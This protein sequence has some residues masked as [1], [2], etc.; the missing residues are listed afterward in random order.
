[1]QPFRS[2][3]LAFTAVT[4]TSL[5]QG[6][7]TFC[8]AGT[9]SHRCTPSIAANVQ[10]NTANHAGCVITT[11]GVEGQ[12][13]G[14][15]FY[16]VDNS[17]F[18]PLVWGVG[19]SSWLC[20]KAPTAR[21]GSLLSSGG[22]AGLCDGSFAVDWG[23]FQAS[24]PSAL[25]NPWSVG[26]KVFVQ[27]WYRDPLAPKTS[28]LSNALKLT[29][30]PPPPVPCVTPVA[31]MALIP[32]GSFL[33][34]SAAASGPPYYGSTLEWP[35]HS[36]TISYCFW[37]GET[38]VTQAQYASLMGANPSFLHGANN[39]VE[40]V[41]WFDARAYC[42]ALTEQ[43]SAQGKVPQGY[44]Y[45]LPTEAEWEYACRAGTTTEFNVGASLFCNQ[46][47]FLYSAHSNSNCSS[48]SHLPVA[49]YAPNARGLCDMHGN[50]WEWCLDSWQYYSGGPATD[51]FVT[52]G[53]YRVCR[54]GGWN[55]NSD[56]CRS[57]Y[58]WISTPEIKFYNMGFRVVL[59]P[60]L[61][62]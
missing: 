5:A 55:N 33:M 24:S 60:I 34:G 58:R 28:N 8:T 43:Q 49:S 12:T 20:V 41:S 37:I 22:T 52:G 16:G 61:V 10:P 48:T 44:Q 3:A 29:L 45:R 46:A 35:V 31:G 27:S 14:L 51:P 54:G 42:A 23:V 25:G 9:S 56:F 17:G 1:M 21:I 7:A 47:K 15:V 4:S 38:E 26:D 6:P 11:S 18:T 13:H 50:V 59:A 32:A 30:L 2:L 40:G 36:V 62:P 39:P 57:A 19:S 53:P